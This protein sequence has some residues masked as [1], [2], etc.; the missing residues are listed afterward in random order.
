MKLYARLNAILQ[1]GANEMALILVATWMG[2]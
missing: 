2:A 1:N